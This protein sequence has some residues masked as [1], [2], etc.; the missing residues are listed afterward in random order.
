MFFVAV[1]GLDTVSPESLFGYESVGLNRDPS[2]GASGT[3]KESVI[4]PDT[5]QILQ[6]A[7]QVSGQVQWYLYQI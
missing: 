3:E 6:P 1:V 4:L 5:S 7:I 2:A